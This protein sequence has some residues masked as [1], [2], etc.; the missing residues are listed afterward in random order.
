MFSP[1]QPWFSLILISVSTAI[2]VFALMRWQLRHIRPTARTGALLLWCGSFW[3]L[4]NALEMLGPGLKAA[5][6]WNKVQYIG[7]APVP[8]LWL[9]L[10]LQFTGYDQ[11]LTRTRLLLLSLPSVL[12]VIMAL[13]NDYHR[14]FFTHTALEISN[15]FVHLETR[16]GP[17]LI[18]LYLYGY[19]LIGVGTYLL[20]QR[21][22][23]SRGFRWQ[24]GMVLLGVTLSVGANI[25]DLSQLSPYPSVKLTPLALAI[26]VPLF[27][28]TLIRARRADLIPVARGSLIHSMG[29]AV[30]VLDVENRIIDLNPAAEA[31]LYHPLATVLGSIMDDVWPEWSRQIVPSLGRAGSWSE[32]QLGE[33]DQRRV[34]DVRRSTLNDWRGQIVGSVIVLREITERKHIENE[35]RRRNSELEILN[36]IITTVSSSLE[37]QEVLNRIA[38]LACS[39]LRMTSAYVCDIDIEADTTIVLAEYYSPQASEAEKVSDLGTTYSIQRDFPDLIEWIL[40]P[41]DDYADHIDDPELPASVRVEM[42]QYG[43]KSILAVPLTHR[44]EHIGY[45]ELW[46]SRH[47]RNFTAA[48]IQWM[49]VMAAQVAIAI[50]NA[51]LFE[52]AQEEITEREIAEA[53]VIQRN[54]ELVALQAAVTKMVFE[55]DLQSVLD[56][57]VK[58]MRLLFNVEG[59]A[60]SEWHRVN[61]MLSTL[62]ENGSEEWLNAELGDGVY[63][64]G[65]YPATKKVLETGIPAQFSINQSDLDQAERQYMQDGNLGL[66]VLLPIT[67]R[68][69]VLGLV[70][71]EDTRTDRV[72][73]E[74][75]MRLAQAL[76]NHAAIAIENA[77]L[78]ETAQQESLRREK[79]SRA[80]QRSEDHYRSLI[81]HTSDLIAIITCDGVFKYISPAVTRLTG[82]QL[83]EAIEQSILDIIHEDDLPEF[84]QLL[85][86]VVSSTG[87]SLPVEVRFQHQD[88][89]WR[90]V[91]VLATNL[92]ELPAVSGIVINA[93]D[94]TDRVHA[95]RQIASSLEEKEVLLKEI[96]HRV[97]N[98]LQIISSL[99]NL[100]APNLQD[101]VALAQFQDSQNR[102]RTMALI[103]ERLYRSDDLARI[104]FDPYL[105]DLTR[106]LLQG[107][108]DQGKGVRLKVKAENVQFDIDTAI[109][110]GLIVNELVSNAL[111]HAF[112][113]ER[114]GEI[115]VE[116]G[117]YD[118]NGHYR[119]TVCDDGVG[120]PPE[121][122]WRNTP[123]LGLQLVNSL[124]YQ[125]DGSL[126]MN[127]ESGTKYFIQFPVKEIEGK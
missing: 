90:Q 74:D 61:N 104:D 84:R 67:S 105:Q 47:K 48:E 123:S 45:I 43:V 13:T 118:G 124:V 76:V 101:P 106:Q 33:G 120:M 85:T 57:V 19:L 58:E 4:T 122:D 77:R 92:L 110:C 119:L 109:P 40:D 63:D 82:Y 25:L 70:E 95:S 127:G 59:C 98:N 54:R 96:H 2:A 10:S 24:G 8:F 94:V 38:Q 73:T 6:F 87:N 39:T 31:I 21:L 99:L 72:L 121:M 37:L 53:K 3:I 50:T 75:E 79:I 116:L 22:L 69:Q 15:S 125:L 114:K 102:I 86:N 52:Q 117:R 91:E 46:E 88:G 93:H 83:A 81:E 66:L 17:F 30:L 34:F 115:S 18:V 26:S 97:K 111:K 100:Q 14:L 5:A 51:R 64:L 55:L 41:Q 62:A 71:L 42:E 1:Q 27:I 103:H 78:Y 9:Y 89:T 7:I 32:F 80:L 107:Y 68:Q 49:K 29:D 11:Q 113:D 23:R 28:V 60:I 20:T 12:C 44:A 16:P 36:H 56:A 35:L 112:P 65:N 126:E 108:Q